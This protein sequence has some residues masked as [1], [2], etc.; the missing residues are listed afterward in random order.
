MPKDEG[1]LNIFLDSD[2]IIEITKAK[3]GIKTPNTEMTDEEIAEVMRSIG[4]AAPDTVWVDGKPMIGR[5]GLG[6]MLSLSL[7]EFP[8][9]FTRHE[10][11]QHN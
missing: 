9:F 5:M 1:K 2:E 11:S 4:S 7:Y 10:L 8:D 3:C 6:V